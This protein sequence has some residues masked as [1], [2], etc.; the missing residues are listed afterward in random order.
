MR[1]KL[2]VLAVPAAVAVL[3]ALNA[4]RA[5]ADKDEK[6]EDKK[7]KDEPMLVHNVF[8]TLKERTP[9]ERKKFVEACKKY[10]TKH[11]G[12]VFFSAGP[13]CEDLKRDLNDLDF[14]VALTIVFKNKAAHDKYQDH[15]RHLEFIKE[16]KDRWKKVRVFDNY[17]TK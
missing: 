12:E 3:L 2:L 17:A 13:L 10:L 5:S 4:Y 15:K 9:E 11:E 6:K 16:N 8:F 14:D 7:D 1:T